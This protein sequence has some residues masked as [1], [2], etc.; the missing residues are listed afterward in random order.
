MLGPDREISSKNLLPYGGEVF[1]VKDFIDPK[2]A[3][4]LLVDLEKNLNWRHE[5]IRLFG[6]T[7]LQPRLTAFH[8]DP[9]REYGYSG[10]KMVPEPWIPSLL[11]IKKEIELLTQEQFTHVL[12][13]MYR[14]GQDS[15]GWHRDN[16]SI[17]GPNPSIASV[18]LGA[19]RIFQLRNYLTKKDKIDLL[20]QSGSLLVMKGESQ[21]QW[22]H[23]LPK[24]KKVKS[25][26]INLTFRHLK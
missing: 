20:L 13:N 15:M 14:D 3:E 12:C 10:I 25:P 11:E 1:Y 8:G 23:Q 19:P 24:T 5:P 22:E 16:E 4:R 26:R 7:I 9:S 2:R 18:T 17:L 6:K 21:H